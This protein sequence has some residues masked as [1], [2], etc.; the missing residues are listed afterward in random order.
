MEDKKILQKGNRKATKVIGIM[1]SEKVKK[2]KSFVPRRC[3][4]FFIR[5]KFLTLFS[6]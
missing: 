2:K 4:S 1:V 3:F 6:K 5:T